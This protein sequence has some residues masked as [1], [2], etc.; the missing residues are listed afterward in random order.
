V[1]LGESLLLWNSS[2]YLELAV[3]NGNASKEWALK[4][5]D[6]VVIEALS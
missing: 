3:R 1:L 5:G 4:V 6:R 2:E